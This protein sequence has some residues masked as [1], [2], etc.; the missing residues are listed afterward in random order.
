MAH[1][2]YYSGPPS[3]HFDGLRFFNPDH[4]VADH[5][6]RDLLRWRLNGQRTHWDTPAAVATTVPQP[7]CQRPAVTMV[8]HASVLIQLGGLNLLVDPVWSER[9][10]PLRW[11]GPRR[12]TR[13]GIA[14]D[15]LPPI[16]AVL[17][18]HNHYDHLDLHTLK[19]LQRYHAPQLITL[20]GNDVLVARALPQMPAT[21]LDWWQSRD[22]GTIEVTATPALHWSSRSLSDRR[23]ALWGGLYLRHGDFSCYVAG[24]TAYGTGWPFRQIRTR[25]GAPDL[26]LLP[27]GA[28]APRWFMQ[29]QHM[30][31]AEAV[32]ALLDCGARQAL[33]VHWGTFQLT[34]EGRLA[35]RELLQAELTR[36]S[37]STDRFAA[38]EVGQ[39]WQPPPS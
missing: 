3:D 16:D 33:G 6:L 8:G 7:H 4:P 5:G 18:T 1:N 10:S 19:R 29:P 35:P 30:D 38:F 24:D 36:R 2:P 11:L 21:A 17:L 20:L 27:I 26:A 14:F 39:V 23:M 28:Y 37:I 32:Q 9:A 34:D 25:L 31:A 13:P 22:I 15:D 12:Y